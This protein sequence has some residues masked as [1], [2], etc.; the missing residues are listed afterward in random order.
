MKYSKTTYRLLTVA[1]AT[2]LLGSCQLGK[3]YTRPD[4]KLPETLDS[5]SVDTASIGDYA[6]EELYTDTTL[7]ALIRKTL[8]YNKDMLIAA[9]RVKELAASKRIQVANM[10]PQVG[11]RV[12]AERERENYG[13]NHYSMDDEFEAPL[14]ERQERGRISRI[15]R[16]PAGLENEPDR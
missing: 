3:H 13:G 11:L 5:L 10:L 16:K 12:Y 8:T 7:Q 1:L 4:L 15:H 9:A 14:G 6:W 2:F